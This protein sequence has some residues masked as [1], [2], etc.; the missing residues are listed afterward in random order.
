MPLPQKKPALEAVASIGFMDLEFY[1]SSFTLPEGRYITHNPMAVMFTPQDKAG[2]AKGQARLGV[3]ITFLN[4][5]NPDPE[6]G[7]EQFYSM[8]QKAHLSWAPSD[9][10]KS[11]LPVAGGPAQGA[12]G[13]TNWFMLLQSLYDCGMPKGAIADLNGIDGIWVH[14][15]QVAEPEGRKDLRSATAENADMQAQ[16]RAPSKIAV[17]GGIEEGGEPWNGGGGIP[18]GTTAPKVNGAPKANG[19]AAR[20]PVAA[21]RVAPKVTPKAPPAPVAVEEE[22]D[23]ETI[24]TNGI[25]EGLQTKP[26][27]MAR[28]ALRTATFKSI[29]KSHSEEVAN[30]TCDAYFAD[31]TVLGAILS[32]LNYSLT[33][34]DKVIPSAD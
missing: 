19:V 7:L 8:G 27:G 12:P 17:C 33:A 23:Y 30:A 25:Y 21:P 16:T 18:A 32:T 11:I 15:T 14:M 22:L 3:M 2:N 31:N 20:A 1:S 13:L 24:A 26:E 6:K 9:D 28:L 4:R 5:D 10:G 34:A 29:K